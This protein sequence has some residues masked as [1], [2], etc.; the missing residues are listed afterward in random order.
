MDKSIQ[1]L[2]FDLIDEQISDEDFHR[3]QELIEDNEQVR[4][5]YLR[6]LRLVHTLGD[7]S[8]R[9]DGDGVSDV[10]LSQQASASRWD[11]RS[12]GWI[13]LAATVLA[14]ASL[15]AFWLGQRNQ[16]ESNVARSS[17]I[18]NEPLQEESLQ[19]ESL[20]EESLIAGHATLRRSVDLVWTGKPAAYREGDVLPQGLV[21]FRSGVAE[22]DFFSGATLIVEGPASLFVESDW[23]VRIDRGRLPSTCSAGSARVRCQNCRLRN[24]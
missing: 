12:P 21:E 20:Y 6:T 10:I 14:L 3:L 17:I 2:I 4:L 1:Q 19:E 15:T 16:P 8:V 9:G 13:S 5:E 11:L 22:F 7:L 18:D 23:E 24:R